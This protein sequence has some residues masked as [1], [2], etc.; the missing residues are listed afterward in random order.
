MY[1][2]GPTPSRTSILEKVSQEQIMEHF[3]GCPVRFGE[4]FNSPLRRDRNPTCSFNWMN[5][6][7]WFRDWAEQ[8]PYNC[9]TLVMRLHNCSHM[10]ALF[11][12]EREMMVRDKPKVHVVE[13]TM[14]EKRK[15]EKRDIQVQLSNWQPEVVDYLKGYH[16]DSKTCRKF[17][18]FPINKVYLDGRRIW[19][20]SRYDPAI[21]Y[22]YG[23]NGESQRWKIYFFKRKTMRFISNTSR[24]SGWIQIPSTGDDLFITKSMKDVACMSMYGIDAISMQS[25]N[26]IPYDYIMDNLKS[27]FKRIHSFYDYDNTGRTNAK[28]LEDLYGI[29]PLFFKNVEGVK[30]F[31]DYV[32]LNGPTKTQKF[33]NHVRKIIQSDS[34]HL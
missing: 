23:N 19:E 20:Y 8:K 31:S 14:F 5:G 24:I 17:N 26:T 32:K 10:E 9:F 15:I 2:F 3:L 4:L 13:E 12:I 6:M 16:L 27:R 29:K 33:V 7:L 28:V 11:V 34:Y 1:G 30:D 22:W 18:I 25:E 21:G